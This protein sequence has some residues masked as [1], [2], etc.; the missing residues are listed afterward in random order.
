MKNMILFLK[1]KSPEDIAL[2]LELREIESKERSK[3]NMQ[4]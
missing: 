3:E 2:L 1:S 4:L